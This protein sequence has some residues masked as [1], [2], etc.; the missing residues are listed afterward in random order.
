M[1][2]F[3]LSRCIQVLLLLKMLSIVILKCVE[4]VGASVDKASSVVKR[5]RHFA[6]SELDR[7]SA[8]VRLTHLKPCCA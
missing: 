1:S 6:P 2:S 7:V 8:T 3:D 4:V 5:E